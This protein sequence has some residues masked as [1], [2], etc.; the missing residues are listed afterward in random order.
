MDFWRRWYFPANATL[1]VVGNFDRTVPEV[2]DLI[3]KTFGPIPPGLQQP[4]GSP[5]A[6]TANGTG[7]APLFNG[8]PADST[9]AA[10]PVALMRSERHLV[11]LASSVASAHRLSPAVGMLLPAGLGCEGKWPATRLAVPWQGS[12]MN[13]VLSVAAPLECACC[14]GKPLLAGCLIL[15]ASGIAPRIL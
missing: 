2:E 10:A 3:R 11:R 12:F 8:Q 15:Q 7:G 6:A 4:D 14:S 13:S 9:A 5:P 1:Y